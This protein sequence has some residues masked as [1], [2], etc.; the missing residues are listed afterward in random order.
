[1][2]FTDD[3]R[4]QRILFVLYNL[5]LHWDT[6]SV[7]RIQPDASEN[8]VYYYLKSIFQ[9]AFCFIYSRMGINNLTFNSLVS[10]IKKKH[11][12]SSN[13]QNSICFQRKCCF[14]IHKTVLCNTPYTQ[15][16]ALTDKCRQKCMAQYSICS[17]QLINLSK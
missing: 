10:T 12:Q 14:T 1:M 7:A 6:I 5:L 8:A 9:A 13:R 3:F 4:W 16:T 2:T 15:T 17:V 11:H